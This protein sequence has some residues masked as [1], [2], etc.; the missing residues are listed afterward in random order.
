MMSLDEVQ[1]MWEKDSEIDRDDLAN[2]SL[3][4][5]MLHCKYWDIYNT[6]KLERWNYY[7]G[8]ASPDVYEEDPFPYKVREK[9]AIIRYIEADEQ[10]SKISLK[11]K[12]YDT[13]LKFLEEIIKSL[14]NRGFAIKN[15]I[16]WM[17]FQNGL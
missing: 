5:P 2:E 7:T 3:R 8:K 15:A 1:K 17:R 10:L 12:Y 4:T 11:I 14:N 9:D 13:L 6:K 16:D